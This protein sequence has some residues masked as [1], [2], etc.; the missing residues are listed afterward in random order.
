VLHLDDMSQLWQQVEMKTDEAMGQFASLFAQGTTGGDAGD[1]DISHVGVPFS[2]D[3]NVSEDGSDVWVHR[4][5]ECPSHT[6]ADSNFS[7]V[8]SYDSQLGSVEWEQRFEDFSTDEEREERE[9]REDQREE[10]EGGSRLNM[11]PAPFTAQDLPLTEVVKLHVE[12]DLS[13]LA[14]SENGSI[15]NRNAAGK[16]RLSGE[17]AIVWLPWPHHLMLSCAL[18]LVSHVSCLVLCLVPHAVLCHMSCVLYLVSCVSRLMLLWVLESE[19]TKAVLGDAAIGKALKR[20]CNKTCTKKVQSFQELVLFASHCHPLMVAAEVSL[21][22]AMQCM[23]QFAAHLF[24]I[25]EKCRRANIADNAQS[26]QTT[27]KSEVFERCVS[28][29]TKKMI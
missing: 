19:Q 26:K 7:I 22:A 27:R 12:G 29:A 24:T 8:G 11:P 15:G 23:D 5:S 4:H 1:P 17:M 21:F 25:R 18:Y 9:G 10:R 14:H 13:S 6:D 20:G 28:R 16:R 2:S 3:F